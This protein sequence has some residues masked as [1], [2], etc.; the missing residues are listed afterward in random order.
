MSMRG[1]VKLNADFFFRIDKRLPTFFLL[2]LQYN[3]QCSDL[4]TD[5]RGSENSNF[6]FICPY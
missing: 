6:N 4:K 5:A 3:R 1:N 2:K